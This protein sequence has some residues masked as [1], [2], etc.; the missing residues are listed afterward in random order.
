MW[1]N[2]FKRQINVLPEGIIFD[3]N[4]SFPIIYNKFLFV[5]ILRSWKDSSKLFNSVT[6]SSDK[7]NPIFSVS[8]IIPRYVMILLG[9]TIL[10]GLTV[11]PILRVL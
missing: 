10:S 5:S 7:W 6:F 3:V 4:Y 8:M 11:S 2:R 9:F 1:I